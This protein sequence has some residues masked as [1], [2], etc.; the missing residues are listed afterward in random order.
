MIVRVKEGGLA[1][2]GD[3]EQVRIT[4]YDRTAGRVMYMSPAEALCGAGLPG[5]CMRLP[6][7]LTLY[8]GPMHPTDGVDVQVQALKGGRAVLGD[9]AT[10]TFADRMSLELDFVLYSSCLGVDCATLDPTR[11]Y[12]QAQGMCGVLAPTPAVSAQSS[13]RVFLYGASYRGNALS[14]YVIDPVTGALSA[15]P[16]APFPTG[17]GPL[18][19]AASAPA[20]ALYTANYDG[21]SLSAYQIDP[22]TGALHEVAGSPFATGAGGAPDAIALSASAKTLYLA[23]SKTDQIEVWSVDVAAGAL[24]ISGAATAGSGPDALGIDPSGRFLY[25]AN[26]NVSSISGYSIRATDGTLEAIGGG[27]FV[28]GRF[29]DALAFH[30]NGRF[31]YVTSYDTNDLRAYQIAPTG[32]LTQV[33]AASTGTNPY[34]VALDPAGHFAYVV[35]SSSLSVSG[36]ALDAGSGALS[37]LPGS[38]YPAPTPAPAALAIEPTGRFLYVGARDAILVYAIAKNGALTPAAAGASSG[39]GAGVLSIV[40]L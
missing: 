2:P 14:A 28:S 25:A 22:G 33:A 13:A 23:D 19:L 39:A 16:G 18:A 4:V 24:S 11:P 35:N 38:P 36:Y 27:P 6:L 8:P 20:R 29:P 17:V 1:V 30:P 37:E 10:F 32:E 5:E 3:L 21:N 12:C 40:Q 15:V 9:A 26:G 34:G 31:A 7:G